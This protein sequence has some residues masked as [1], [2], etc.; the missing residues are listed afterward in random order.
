M[1]VHNLAQGLQKR[2]YDIHVIYSRPSHQD[3]AVPEYPVSWVPHSHHI[4]AN[5]VPIAWEVGR[6]ARKQ[7]FDIYHATGVDGAIVAGWPGRK[8]PLV[9]SEFYPHLPSVSEF[10]SD[11]KVADPRKLYRYRYFYTSRC[12]ARR[13]AH[14]IVPSQFTKKQVMSVYDIPS[15]RISAVPWG[16]DIALF[17]RENS[18]VTTDDPA[19]KIAWVARV[20]KTKG[21]DVLL[22]AFAQVVSEIPAVQ[23]IVVGGGEVEEARAQSAYLGILEKVQFAGQLPLKD[24]AEVLKRSHIFVLPSRIESFGG[25]LL[26][27]MASRLAIVASRVGGIPEVVE[28]EETGLLVPVGNAT[29]LATA[30]T[31]LIK[32]IP[33]RER[34]A[35]AGYRQVTQ[36]G[37]FTWEAF[38]DAHCE[39]YERLTAA[40]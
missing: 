40:R 9:Y 39:I 14:I 28:H 18:P 16:V 36:G 23:L 35:A 2:S 33:L 24:Y 8:S 3:S 30:L 4:L 5:A 11:G 15:E 7:P 38:I 10:R 25:V 12:T 32:D 34:L 27:A 29:E 19:V 1:L 17:E 37:R 20:D 31:C 22:E 26:D 13:A 6:L 21:I